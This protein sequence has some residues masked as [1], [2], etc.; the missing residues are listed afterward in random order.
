MDR[1]SR[2]EDVERAYGIQVR[3]A[4]YG[5]ARWGAVGFGL[6]VLGHY[7]WPAFR[8]QTVAFKGFL[9]STITIFGLV[10][11]AENALLA[12]E[13]QR[14]QEETILR[15]QARIDLARQGLVATEPAIAQWKAERARREA[16]TS[17]A[18]P[19]EPLS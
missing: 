10:I 9:V 14:R 5:A 18:Q 19:Q 1:A 6:A 4:V 11:T 13:A 16:E 8:R 17:Q 15:R 12:Y 2:R 3:A 7:S